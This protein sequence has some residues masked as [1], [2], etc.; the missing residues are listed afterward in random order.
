M[1]DALSIL[2]RLQDDG[3]LGS[4]AI[5]GAMAAMFYAEP[6]TTF[7]LDVFVVLPQ[8]RALLTLNPIQPALR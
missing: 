4:Y 1:R 6:V 5:G 3:V 7:D 8:Q 2:N